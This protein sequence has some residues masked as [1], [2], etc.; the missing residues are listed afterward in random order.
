MVLES[1]Q[2]YFSS[3]GIPHL[4]T[5]TE[6]RGDKEREGAKFLGFLRAARRLPLRG[7]CCR[8]F[9]SPLAAHSLPVTG[10]TA[11]RRI[12]GRNSEKICPPRSQRAQGF[13]IDNGQIC[14]KQR[15]VQRSCRAWASRQNSRNIQSLFLRTAASRQPRPPPPWGPSQL[16]HILSPIRL[17]R[18]TSSQ[19]RAKQKAATSDVRRKEK[20]VCWRCY[21][22][23]SHA[24]E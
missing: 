16:T 10:A 1:L 18:P 3:A 11:G 15:L 23:R 12:W 5:R 19:T 21:M 13:S 22:R 24:T 4:P 20:R 7:V 14:R 6:S 17:D 2:K 8:R 9:Y